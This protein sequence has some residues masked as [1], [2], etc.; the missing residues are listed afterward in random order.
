MTIG[1]PAYVLLPDWLAATVQLPTA[2][3]VSVLPLT[4]QT[5]GVVDA[6]D[7]ARPDEAVAASAG[8][9]VPRVWLPGDVKLMVCASS[10]AAATVKLTD[11]AGAAA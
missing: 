6:N 4:V 10:G 11:T 8:G 9:A 2:T 7:T 3:S 5:L 1:A